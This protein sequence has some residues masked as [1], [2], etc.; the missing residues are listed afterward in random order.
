MNNSKTVKKYN[1]VIAGWA[2]KSRLVLSLFFQMDK[3]IKVTL[4][5]IQ[6]LV[7]SSAIELLEFKKIQRKRHIKIEVCVKSSVLRLFHVGYVVQ[8]KQ[9]ALSVSWHEW[10]SYERKE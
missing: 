7:L 8:N 2:Y 10:F 5:V 6:I 4:I 1:A 3:P 9:C